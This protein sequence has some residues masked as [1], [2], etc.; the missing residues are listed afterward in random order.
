[1]VATDGSSRAGFALV[2]FPPANRDSAGR[3]VLLL[4]GLC[5]LATMAIAGWSWNLMNLMALPLIWVRGWITHFH[6]TGL[7]PA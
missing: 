2:R 1:L 6:P 7:A 4:S 5:L 3:S